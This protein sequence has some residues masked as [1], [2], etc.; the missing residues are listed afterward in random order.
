MSALPAQAGHD[1]YIVTPNGACH[2]VAAGQTS[3]DD[4]SHGGY[5]RF[6]D[7]GLKPAGEDSGK[8][9]KFSTPSLRNV[10]LTAP[11]MHDGRF[12]TLAQVVAHYSSG[13]HRSET[14]D[15]NLAKHPK[16]GLGLS[17]G[18]QRALVAFLEALTDPKY[19]ASQSGASR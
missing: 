6:H 8:D 18:D 17:A 7:N 2:Q 12:A 10:G 4:P 19:G 9:G 11:Y 15:P 5:H 13:L 3:I 1:H 14:L 16:A